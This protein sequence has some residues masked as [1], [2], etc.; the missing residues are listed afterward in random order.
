MNKKRMNVVQLMLPDALAEKMEKAFR[1]ARGKDRDALLRCLDEAV[2]EFLGVME[3]SRRLE[4][5]RAGRAKLI[6][7]D[8]VKRRLG[9]A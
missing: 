2:D 6:P 4:D 1:E 5:V 3:A 8:E 9:A 7:L